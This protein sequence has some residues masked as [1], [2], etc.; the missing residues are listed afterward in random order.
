M[1]R[2]QLLAL[3]GFLY[4]DALD[5]MGFKSADYSNEHNVFANLEA[6]C[7]GD[8]RPNAV[9][10]YILNR[11]YEKLHRLRLYIERGTYQGDEK[12]DSDILDGINQLVLL[13]A[14]LGV[15]GD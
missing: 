7:A 6:A 14:R 1:T 13:A 5:L 10:H 3:H 4:Q 9:E 2:D 8:P 15:G 12:A 11:T